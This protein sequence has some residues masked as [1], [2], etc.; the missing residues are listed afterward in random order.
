MLNI[1]DA[2]FP[3]RCP[4]CD[5]VIRNRDIC[6]ECEAKQHFVDGETCRKCGKKITGKDGIYCYDCRRTQ[7]RFDRGFAVFEYEY[8]RTSLYRFKYNGRA[9]YA[10]YYARVTKEKLG[11]TLEMIGI[12][13]FIPVPI[14][15]SRLAKR[16]YNQ[17]G[18]YARRLSELCSIPVRED[19]IERPVRTKAQKQLG[20]GERQKNLKKAFKLH[21]DG[22]ELNKVCIVDDIYTTGSTI[23]AIATL[24]KDAGVK[25]VYFVAIAIG[26]G[27]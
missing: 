1:R 17:A 18:E 25:E 26:K 10:G 27:M 8:I 3:R 6:T 9:E 21:S 23:N 15:R 24:L 2:L 20:A 5:R 14:H 22:V 7:K 13:A 12:E 19:I 16:G 4:V 11:R